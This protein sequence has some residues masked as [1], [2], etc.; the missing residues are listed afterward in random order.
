MLALGP[1]YFGLFEALGLVR[2][3]SCY[4][5]DVWV[6]VPDKEEAGVLQSA[7]VCMRTLTVRRLEV[8]HCVETYARQPSNPTKF[9]KVQGLKSYTWKVCLGPETIPFG[10]L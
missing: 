10:Y 8:A 6:W 1:T 7:G 9:R 5:S 2:D 4:A 3:C